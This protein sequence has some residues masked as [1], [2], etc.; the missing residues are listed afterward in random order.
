MF[1]TKKLVLIGVLM[2]GLVGSL[3][4][5]GKSG[6][7]SSAASAKPLTAV[8]GS[9]SIRSRVG[10]DPCDPS[11]NGVV[12]GTQEFVFL[13]SDAQIEVHGQNGDLLASG[14]IDRDDVIRLTMEGDPDGRVELTVRP[15][16]DP[17]GFTLTG[18]SREMSSECVEEI[19]L[20]L[21]GVR[22]SLSTEFPLPPCVTSELFLGTDVEG[23]TLDSPGNDFTPSCS[24]DG[25]G[26]DVAWLFTAPADADYVF[27]AGGL[28]FDFWPV[29]AVYA[30]DCATELTCSEFGQQVVTL[31]EG[32][33][34]VVVV[35]GFSP[36]ASGNYFLEVQPLWSCWTRVAGLG[37]QTFSPS[38][39]G[40]DS[41]LFEAPA[42]GEYA[43]E[44]GD[45]ADVSVTDYYCEGTV[46]EDG[47]TGSV[48]YLEAG[49]RVVVTVVTDLALDYDL[50]ISPLSCWTEVA[51]LGVNE[52][53]TTGSTDDFDLCGGSGSPDAALVFLAPAD[54][55]YRIDAV[56]TSFPT[57][58]AVLV[59]ECD[60][61]MCSDVAESSSAD[62]LEFFL[63]ANE[64][65]VIVVD[66]SQPG[67]FGPYRVTIGVDV[68]YR[69]NCGGTS[70]SDPSASG[71]AWLADT[72]S[73]PSP[74]VNV[75]ESGNRTATRNSPITAD[76]TVPASMPIGLFSTERWD[77]S[78]GAEMQWS[79][80]VPNGTY[81]VR[82]GLC[83]IVFGPGVRR[84]SVAIEG[85]LVLEDFEQAVELGQF[86]ASVKTFVVEVV[87]GVVDIDFLHVQE[88]PA[89]KAIEIVPA[90]QPLPES[91]T[92]GDQET[93]V[94]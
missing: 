38:S 15:S 20:D 11:R 93:S 12:E 28:T 14:T 88:N 16:A 2:S 8:A 13:Q 44:A 77:P 46:L 45:D 78:S 41:Y 89:I 80:P 76:S 84:F 1:C 68:H 75:L 94:D 92:P 36:G 55:Y 54:G 4:G 86:V 82:L 52:G 34:V 69:V 51:Q 47:Q 71:P 58:L 40:V 42:R 73:A 70:I 7:G 37:T 83:E 49:E 10:D 61:W 27:F 57:T 81:E 43:F 31:S 22:F 9:W 19:R 3:V 63:R 33:R 87:D 53:D 91:E 25:S 62:H 32:Q 39:S 24:I 66:G 50:T 29:V 17:L 6:G 35:D 85:D 18:S 26:D 5:C 65:I 48:A 64:Q 72:V 56:G 74:F 60:P 79:F 23:S 30:D 21:E 67:S 59:D 90:S